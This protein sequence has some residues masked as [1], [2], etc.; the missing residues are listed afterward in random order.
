MSRRPLLAKS[1]RNRAALSWS[2]AVA[3]S[4]FYWNRGCL[5]E[6]LVEP[7]LPPQ[8]AEGA[9]IGQREGKAILILITHRTQRKAAI[10]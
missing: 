8:V 9:D 5:A 3:M 7:L 10:L 4:A 1:C 2:K 6:R